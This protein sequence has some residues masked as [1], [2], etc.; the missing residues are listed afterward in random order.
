MT[1]EGKWQLLRLTI[2]IFGPAACVAARPPR[3]DTLV[4][5][6]ALESTL[7]RAMWDLQA[8]PA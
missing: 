1:P 8:V 5:Q 6:A 4:M 2:G 3:W 7:L